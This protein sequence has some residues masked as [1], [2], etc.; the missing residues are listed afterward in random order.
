MHCIYTTLYSFTLIFSL[1]KV[2]IGC[3]KDF[4]SYR[5]HLFSKKINHVRGLVNV[6]AFRRQTN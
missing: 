3:I 2:S 1:S 4:E 5:Y 6:Y